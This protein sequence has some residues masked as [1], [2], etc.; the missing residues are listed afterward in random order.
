LRQTDE[1]QLLGGLCRRNA[2]REHRHVRR[3]V[4]GERLSARSIS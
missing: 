3:D 1:T 4:L 2:G